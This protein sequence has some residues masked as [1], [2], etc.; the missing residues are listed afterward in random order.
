M[1]DP[2]T[3]GRVVDAIRAAWSEQGYGPTVREIGE[4]AG[5]RGSA[6]LQAAIS[7]LIAAGAVTHQPRLPRT[8]RVVDA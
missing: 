8:L 3:D 6:T 1:V 4:R 7:R 2:R 5:V